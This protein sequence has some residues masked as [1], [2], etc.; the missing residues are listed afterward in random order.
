LRMVLA[1]GGTGGHVFPGIAVADEFMERDEESEVLFIGIEKGL[2]ARVVP[3]EGYTIKFIK[4]RGVLGRS[5]FEKIGSLLR[6]LGSVFAAKAI[7]K[8]AG[9]DVVVG[10]GG[11]VSVAP[12]VAARLLS[13]PIVV[14]EQNLVP[15]YANKMLAKIADA[16]AVTYHESMS[17]F[18]RTKTF[19][20]GNPIRKMIGGVSREAAMAFFN[21]DPEKTTVLVLGGS[22]GASAINN[23][24][25][26]ALNNML[27]MRTEIQFLHQTG[28]H[29][30]EGVRRAYRKLEFGA[31][32]AP[33]VYQMAEAYAAADL[34]ISRAGATTLAEL[35]ALGK[36]SIIIPYPYA[37]GHQEFNA[38]KLLESGAAKMITEGEL[39]GEKLAAMIKELCASEEARNE[40][41]AQARALGRPDAAKKVVDIAMSM[42]KARGS[43]V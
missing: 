30:Y 7:L 6:I 5:V 37:G 13:L 35:T 14:M 24:M 27:D 15:G 18:P 20:T 16:V 26:T 41:A 28:E 17:F 10:T 23:T 11:Y 29:D 19:L 32:V 42:V 40:M 3:K 12:L 31:M 4:A 33:F 43:H 1:G 22:G 39:T 2:E 8:E 25:L 21:L 38:R 34:V 9:A 36:P